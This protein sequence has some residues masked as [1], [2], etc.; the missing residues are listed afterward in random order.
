[1]PGR[2]RQTIT[3]R[4]LLAVAVLTICASIL[5][6]PAAARDARNAGRT[7]R[8]RQRN[9]QSGD[10]LPDTRHSDERLVMLW[11]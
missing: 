2:I 1:M 10:H 4:S 8:H 3:R 6:L 11:M 5:L 9:L 7:A